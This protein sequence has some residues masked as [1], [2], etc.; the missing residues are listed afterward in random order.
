MVDLGRRGLGRR[1]RG[2]LCDLVGSLA[3]IRL[4]VGPEIALV[5]EV[6]KHRGELLAVDLP[7]AVGVVLYGWR[8]AIGQPLGYM[9]W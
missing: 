4:L 9:G 7:V 5:R 6:G 2:R 1:G 3:V 8:V